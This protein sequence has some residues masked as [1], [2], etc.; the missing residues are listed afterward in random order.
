[1]SGVV[2]GRVPKLLKIAKE[3]NEVTDNNTRHF[4]FLLRKK[5]IVAIGQNNIYKTHPLA[6]NVGYKWPTIHSELSAIV[7]YQDAR[8]ITDLSDLT[9]VN[10]RFLKD[11]TLSVSRP[12]VYC[13]KL[14]KIFNVPLIIYSHDQ[15]FSSLEITSDE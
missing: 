6:N 1:M 3:L 5:N 13:R 4:S 11:G 7:A 8:K 15:G 14:L 9:M 12:C 2:W 10:F